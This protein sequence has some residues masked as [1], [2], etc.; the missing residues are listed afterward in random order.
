MN[1]KSRPSATIPFA[2]IIVLLFFGLSCE[3]TG[4]GGTQSNPTL[5]AM[6]ASIAGTATAEEAKGNDAANK[7][8]TAQAN[9]TATAEVVRVTQTARA[10][11][12]SE[13]Q[14]ATA[15]IAAPI[16]AELPF[17][18]VDT[19]KGHVGWIGESE[20]ISITG[21]Q[22]TGFVNV[23]VTAANFVLAGDLT[24]DTQYGSSGCG[25]MFRSD[26]DRNKPSAYMVLA[27]R[28][29]S[30]HAIFT[31]L[32]KGDL[33]NLHDFFPKTNDKSFKADN[34]TTNRLA[35]VARG[36]IIEIYS[37]TAK[38][39][40]I[41]T[42]KPPTPMNLPPPPAE[43]LNKKDK[44]ALDK[45]L[46]QVD[47]YQDIVKQMQS[48]YNLALSNFTNKPA[49]FT[50]G[51]LALIALSESGRTQCKFDNTWLWMIEE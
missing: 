17:Y 25:F 22:Q 16:L 23:P 8:K 13:A 12:Q 51:F 9:S 38:I 39:G 24:W 35:I 41:D 42:T 31:A 47:E 34:G 3:L 28:F 7:L 20:T 1:R 21:Y 44:A 19:T 43:P 14:L 10:A 2:L 11:N 48:Q 50:D 32:A 15:T 4:A 27:T 18:D 40:E 45:Y 49:I 5:T 46:K 33:A 30:G 36:N 26:G 6:S 29:A 37:N